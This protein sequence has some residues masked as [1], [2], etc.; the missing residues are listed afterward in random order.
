MDKGIYLYFFFFFR[1]KSGS[2]SFGSASL[3]L[4][5]ERYRSHGLGPRDR[6]G[7]ERTVSQ[8]GEAASVHLGLHRQQAATRSRD[9]E[10]GTALLVTG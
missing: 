10:A 9:E 3:L 5:S 4:M 7:R 8:G 2:F 6:K 1:L